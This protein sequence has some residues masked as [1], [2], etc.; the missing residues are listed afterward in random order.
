MSSHY[1]E[2]SAYHERYVD[3]S[4]V[5]CPLTAPYICIQLKV[6]IAVPPSNN[7]DIFANDVVGADIGST[8][9]L[10][11]DGSLI[12]VMVLSNP[13]LPTQ[14]L[15]S[16]PEVSDSPVVVH[17]ALANTDQDLS[18]LSLLRS[19][20]PFFILSRTPNEAYRNFPVHRPPSLRTLS[21]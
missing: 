4:R 2:S 19:N 21:H 11:R 15:H 16:L 9:L 6:A 14:L 18:N 8:I 3:L 10:H 13:R 12:S 1:P 20:V 17:I 7:V 5:T